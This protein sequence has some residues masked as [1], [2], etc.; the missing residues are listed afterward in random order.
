M[1]KVILSLVGL[2][3][4]CAIGYAIYG[5]C[6]RKSLPQAP[7]NEQVMA[8]LE[9][10][11]CFVCHAKEPNL[12]FYANLPVMKDVMNEHC[13]HAYL[14]SD[15]ETAMAIPDQVDEAT[16]A[17]IEHCVLENTMPIMQYQMVHWG[18]GFNKEER[19]ILAEWIA[20][21]RAAR[22][23]TG[24]NAEAFQ[25]EPL[26][27]LP[28]AIPTDSAK[29]ALGFRMYNDKRLSLD[30]TISCYT[31]HILP[32][33][34]VS[35]PAHRTSEG[36]YGQ[37]GGVNAPTVYNACYNVQQFWNGRAADLQEQ[38]A[39]PPANPVEMGDQTWDDIVARLRQDQ[40]LVKE[41]EQ[42]YPGEGLTQATVTNAIA[43]FEKT[44]I[45]PNCAFDQYLKGNEAAITDE[46]KR[47]YTAFKQNSCAA[48][49]VGVIAGGQSFERLG[50]YADYF[51]DRDST[52]AF[53]PDD[54][55]LKGFTGMESDLYKFKVPTLRNVDATA[56]YFHDGSISTLEDAV[57]AM[58]KYELGK[59]LDE[60][61][62]ADLVAFM[63][64]LNA[65]PKQ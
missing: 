55:G 22:F 23:A 17:K 8:I 49:H 46:A 63:K 44:L 20:T 47:G 5:F 43:E 13:L 38:A 36:I 35:N 4:V 26:Q 58:A 33:G 25:S 40:A 41:F 1:K 28:N 64:T 16:L 57:R 6:L 30:G 56:P 12:P 15:L 34:G 59:D 27:A 29:V 37:F 31:C 21:T 7:I 65:L 52:I 10:N 3:F 32:E 50:I 14:F 51:A 9:Q 11:D 18:T 39:G 54:E 48:C 24:I 19:G 2:A 62:V 61:T 45:T 53:G 42:L 60:Q